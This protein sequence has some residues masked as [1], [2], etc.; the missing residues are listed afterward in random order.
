MMGIEPYTRIRERIDEYHRKS[1]QPDAGL[2]QLFDKM[3]NEISTVIEELEVAEEE[4]RQQ[5][6]ELETT[7]EEISREKQRYQ[8]LFEL[9]PDAHLVTDPTGKIREANRAALRMF[10]HGKGYLVGKPIVA[11]V[12]MK[13]RR[14]LRNMLV[15]VTEPVELELHLVPSKA[16]ELVV[17]VKINPD[18]NQNGKVRGIRWVIRDITER[19]QLIT[20]LRFSEERFRM[21]FNNAS[22]GVM[23]VDPNDG[24]LESN[25]AILDFLN[26][27][28]EELKQG[29]FH[30]TVYGADR[31]LFRRAFNQVR[32]DPNG[33]Q[34]IEIRFEEQTGEITWGKVIL[35]L[36]SNDSTDSGYVIIMVEDITA[37]K[38]L[39]EERQEMH[40]R[41][42]DSVEAE[43]IRLAREL[44][45]NPL[46]DLYGAMFQLIEISQS[47]QA[48]FR[49][50]APDQVTEQLESIQEMMQHVIRSL[51]ATCGELR[52]TALSFYGLEK[53]IR[54]YIGSIEPLHPTLKFHLYL[55]ND[56]NRLSE[57]TVLALFRITQQSLNNVLRHAQ[58]TQIWI[59]L[60]FDEEQ[61]KLVIE[62]NGVGFEIPNSM[63]ELTREGH[64]GLAGI[65][66]RVEA[67][68]GNLN[69]VAS[70]GTGTRIEVSVP[71]N[72]DQL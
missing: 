69:L 4:L 30:K 17:S 33:G 52:P 40:Q 68:G 61:A 1:R 29:G 55:S 62:D 15:R 63:V 58:A 12:S 25:Q 49:Q 36:L 18:L 9:A 72:G 21:I 14:K 57:R 71:L 10:N 24:V 56:D 34:K 23:L 32:K 59:K 31:P 54:S 50:G 11:Y 28:E 41:L 44:H 19:E 70:P 20:A 64:Y 13:D 16:Q 45:D 26:C 35:S 42:M 48:A 7:Q 2:Q 60:D 66:E 5:N 47:V 53:A 37:Q 8:E 43:R 51:R 27:T 39:A 6:D 67:I 46:Q 3:L 38:Q 65:S 22:L